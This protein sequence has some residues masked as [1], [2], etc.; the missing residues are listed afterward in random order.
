MTYNTYY[1]CHH[2]A[3]FI[4]TKKFDLVRHLTKQKKCS[5]Y[6]DS[7]FNES[8]FKETAKLSENKKFY[9]K[10]EDI[11]NINK[12][13]LIKYVEES[14]K[15]AT[16]KPD[17]INLNKLNVDSNLNHELNHELNHLSE[18]V[19][20]NKEE[21]EFYFFDEK[22]QRYKCHECLSEFCSKQL[23]ENHI[24]NKV[25]CEKATKINEAIERAKWKQKYNH[26]DKIDLIIK[27]C[28]SNK[29]DLDHLNFIVDQYIQLINEKK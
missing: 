6:N 24:L 12:N 10:K 22:I 15:E 29:V 23:I 16:N 5:S 26:F 13:E 3:D 7:F 21:F 8:I 17:T 20:I 27:K 9:F 2:C 28:V 14:I 19:K 25:K 18:I 11:I 4:T 1:I